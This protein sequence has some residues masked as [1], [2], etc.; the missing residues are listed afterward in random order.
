[1]I[2][3]LEDV[4]QLVFFGSFFVAWVTQELSRTVLWLT[5]AAV[6]ALI[7]ALLAAFRLL[8][9]LRSRRGVAE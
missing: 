8:N 7:L 4:L 1:M 6:A 3:Q 5:I 2:G 9:G